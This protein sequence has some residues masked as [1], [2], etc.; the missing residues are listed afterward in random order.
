MGH[1]AFEERGSHVR[2]LHFLQQIY[3]LP[4]H[5]DTYV[6]TPK[7]AAYLHK[8]FSA[9]LVETLINNGEYGKIKQRHV[10][11]YAKNSACGGGESTSSNSSKLGSCAHM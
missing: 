7:M 9:K 10:E 2:G 3:E 1:A 8:E 6:A 5:M 11:I 4:P